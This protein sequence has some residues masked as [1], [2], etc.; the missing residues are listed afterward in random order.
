MP[1]RLEK[2]HSL[3]V[4]DIGRLEGNTGAEIWLRLNLKVGS[5]EEIK[6]SLRCCYCSCR[7]GGCF[8]WRCRQR[9]RCRRRRRPGCCFRSSSLNRAFQRN[10]LLIPPWPILSTSKKF[11]LSIFRSWFI[12]DISFCWSQPTISVVLR[13]L[14]LHTCINKSGG[15]LLDFFKC[16]HE[17]YISGVKRLE[18]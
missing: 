16:R 13:W 3:P 11:L 7:R 6:D 12:S 18:Q 2:N 9:R 14:T 4:R 5:I 8:C 10:F 1:S 15:T 17:V